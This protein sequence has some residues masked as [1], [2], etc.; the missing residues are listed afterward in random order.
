MTP[1]ELAEKGTEYLKQAVLATL[2]ES[3][4]KGEDCVKAAEIGRRAGIYSIPSNRAEGEY[5]SF[6]DAIISTLL[7]L[8]HKEGKVECP[9]RKN[10]KRIGWRLA[11]GHFET[12]T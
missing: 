8:L 11:S 10:N 12:P 9:R 4:N 1:V 6:P 3:R 7:D 5:A 2:V